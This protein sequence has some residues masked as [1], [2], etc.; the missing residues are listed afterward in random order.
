MRTGRSHYVSR[1]LVNSANGAYV[2][3][4]RNPSLGWHPTW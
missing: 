3:K 4:A 2:H 1:D